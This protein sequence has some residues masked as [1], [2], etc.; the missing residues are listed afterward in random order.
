[1]LWRGFYP[2][3]HDRDI[4]PHLWYADYLATYVARDVRQMLNVR[5]LVAFQRFVRLCAGRTSQILNLSALAADCGITHKTAA[6]WLSL[7]EASYIV[8]RLAPFYRNFGKRLVKSPK[9]YFLDSGFAAWLTGIRTAQEIETSSLRG[10]LFETWLVSEFGKWAWNHRRPEQVHFWRDNHG[11]EIDLVVERGVALAAVE[12]KAGQTL[13][14]DWFGPLKSFA[15]LSG[16]RRAFLVYGG[17]AGASRGG[18]E[19]VPWRQLEDV[20]GGILEA[21]D[22]VGSSPSGAV[23]SEGNTM[24]PDS[25]GE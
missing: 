15:E 4:P 6:S 24:K 16:A 9:L 18:V 12:C 5:D 19:I 17:A 1:M 2:P 20:F 21:F 13:A 8:V 14:S 10:A 22:S 3:V 11:V 25:G 23:R 7:L